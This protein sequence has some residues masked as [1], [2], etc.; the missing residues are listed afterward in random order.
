MKAAWKSISKQPER[1]LGAFVL[2]HLLD[3]GEPADMKIEKQRELR[4]RA[5]Y[6]G[7]S[8]SR[9]EAPAYG[10][11]A[12]DHIRTHVASLRR[13]HPGGYREFVDTLVPTKVARHIKE[14]AYVALDG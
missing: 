2:C 14:F 11:A 3:T 13:Q 5:M 7:E 8:V 1:Q 4:S 6:G 9:G 12:W 10:Q